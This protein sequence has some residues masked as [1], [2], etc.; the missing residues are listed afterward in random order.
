MVDRRNIHWPL[1]VVVRPAVDAGSTELERLVRELTAD[2]AQF[3]AIF[4][5]DSAFVL[6]GGC[7]EF[8]ELVPENRTGR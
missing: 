3:M 5:R 1:Q 2:H 6:I 8:H 4:D 7:D